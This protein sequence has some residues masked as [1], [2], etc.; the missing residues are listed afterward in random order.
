MMQLIAGQGSQAQW[1]APFRDMEGAGEIKY[2][3][4]GANQAVAIFQDQVLKATSIVAPRPAEPVNLTP[5]L[6]A[7]REEAEMRSIFGY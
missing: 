1:S 3:M 7:A 5:D 4:I 6:E 2:V